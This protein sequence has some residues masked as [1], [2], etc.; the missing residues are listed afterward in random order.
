MQELKHKHVK[1][2]CIHPSLTDTEE[3]RARTG[4]EPEAQMSPDDVAEA[5]L[6]P[7]RVSP[8][9]VP[10]DIVLGLATPKG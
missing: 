6:L 8:T 3:S 7:F 2:V 1:V 10:A 4:T 9:C 5:A